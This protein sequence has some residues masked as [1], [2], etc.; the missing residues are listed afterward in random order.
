[1]LDND[2]F[3]NSLVVIKEYKVNNNSQFTYDYL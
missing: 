3:P 2:I 1:M